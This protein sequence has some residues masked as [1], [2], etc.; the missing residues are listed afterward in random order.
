VKAG[1][2]AFRFPADLPAA[3]LCGTALD[4]LEQTLPGPT[5]QRLSASRMIAGRAPPTPG[6]TTQRKTVPGGNHEA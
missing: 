1:R 4:Q 3:R 2:E 5:Y 6:S